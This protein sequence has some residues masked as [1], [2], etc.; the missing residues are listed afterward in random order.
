MMTSK[1]RIG[2]SPSSL[3][4]TCDVMKFSK[5]ADKVAQ[6]DSIWIPES[7][8]REAFSMLGAISQITKRVRLG[9]SIINIYAR[10]PATTAMAAFTLE[11]LAPN[12]VVIGLGAGTPVLAENWHGLKFAHPLRRIEEFT[13][14]FNLVTSGENVNYEGNYFTIKNFRILNRP[15]GIKIPI[16]FAAVN[17]KMI[18]LATRISD[19][20]ILYLRPLAKLRETVRKIISALERLARKNFEICCVFI[21]AISDQDRELARKRAAKTLAFYISVGRYYREF[22]SKNGFKREVNLIT[23]NYNKFGLANASLAVSEEMLRSLTIY[24]TREDCLKSLKAVHD[25][26]IS[27]PILQVNPV[28]NSDDTIKQSLSLATFV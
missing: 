7:W 11:D 19:G 6:A 15:T 5:L 24:G 8:G 2:F 20:I 18:E 16:Y 26:G 1:V 28:G 3:F 21:T 27:L 12:R 9:T 10:S 25:T 14:C 4:R 23:S 13:D 17:E 22:I